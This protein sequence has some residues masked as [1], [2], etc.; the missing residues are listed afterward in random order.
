MERR[1]DLDWL[2][3]IAFAVLIF[4]HISMLFAV[5]RGLHYKS[6]YK[7]E[8]LQNFMLLVNRWRLLLLFFIS[9]VASRFFLH[10]SILIVAA[11]Y[12]SSR[13]LGLFLEVFWVI[14]ITVS[15]YLMSYEVLKRINIFGQLLGIS[16]QIYESEY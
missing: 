9:G 10:Q 8:F 2:R 1:Y 4:Y 13:M 14:V 12:R 3:V 16:P 11:F 15:C 7:S 5:D 6:Q